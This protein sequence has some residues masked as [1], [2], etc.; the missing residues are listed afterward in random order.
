[1]ASK[2]SPFCSIILM[3]GPSF[4]RSERWPLLL[5][6]LHIL[7][8]CSYTGLTKF[9]TAKQ[10]IVSVL[11]LCVKVLDLTSVSKRPVAKEVT[12]AV[13]VLCVK[14]LDLTS[15]SKNWLQQLATVSF[16]YCVWRCWTWPASPK[17]GYTYRNKWLFL[18]G[19]VCEG[20]GP[21]QHHQKLVT[22]TE[23]SDCFFLVL[24][25]KVLDLTSITKNWLHLQ[26]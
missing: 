22:L 15:V 4:L 17:T 2:S 7:L 24:C 8:S 6:L 23:I 5:L 18:S 16:W 14:V 21:N 26:K 10:V 13:L 19:I 20:A 25:V 12:V 9:R 1:M 11:V 3:P